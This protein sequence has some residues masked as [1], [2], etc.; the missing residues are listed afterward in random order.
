MSILTKLATAAVQRQ[1]KRLLRHVE[2]LTGDKQMLAL[3]LDIVADAARKLETDLGAAR[4]RIHQ[5]EVELAAE[6]SVRPVS[7]E[8]R[9]LLGKQAARLAGQGEG[10]A[11]DAEWKRIQDGA[12]DR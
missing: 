1:N 11:E 12:G 2:E 8:L 4:D 9:V 3:G 6:K 10:A 5:L 7:P